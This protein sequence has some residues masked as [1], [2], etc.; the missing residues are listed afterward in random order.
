MFAWRDSLMKVFSKGQKAQGLAEYALV[1]AFI[2]ALAVAVSMTGDS[3]L[4]DAVHDA[5]AYVTEVLQSWLAN[6]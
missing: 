3:L 6:L 1:L 5:F 4:K 2:V